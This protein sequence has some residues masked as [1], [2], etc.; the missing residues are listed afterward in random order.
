M[1]TSAHK[2][3]LFLIRHGETVDNVAQVYAGRRDSE[4]TNHGYQQATRLGLHFKSLGLRFT[5]LFSSHLQRAAK[6][7]ALIQ[8]AQ[9]APSVGSDAIHA[10]PNVV[11][12]PVLMEQDFGFY[13]GKKWYDK[14]ANTGLSGREHHRQ[15]HTDTPGF[16]DI[17]P[18]ESLAR[19]ADNFIDLHLLPLFHGAPS[20]TGH[21]VAIVSH[22]IMLS[23]LWKRLLLR[24]PP[25]SVA[26][27]PELSERV[28]C[29]SLEHLGGWSNTGYLELHLQKTMVEDL[30]SVVIP[31]TPSDL[32]SRLTGDAPTNTQ[33]EMSRLEDARAKFA[34]TM[35][36]TSST[37]DTRSQL[38]T[39]VVK[40]LPVRLAHGWTTV[41]QTM[42]GRDHLKGL[43]RTGGGVGSARHDTSQQNVESFFKR[44]KLG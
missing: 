19:R 20:A 41:I 30:V 22:G 17:E 8:V 32:D 24:L 40:Q 2:V 6:T 1:G 44:R 28:R 31:A 5:H 3:K 16:V 42:N 25:K 13:E 43:K 11:Q 9:S 38:A 23:I 21:V 7:A 29:R 15:S 34:S 10:V 27:S 18:V 39:S 33:A 12:L 14:P 35:V 36:G 26:F 37:D 4:L